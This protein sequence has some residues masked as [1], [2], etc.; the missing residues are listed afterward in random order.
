M[1]KIYRVSNDACD[2][3]PVVGDVVGEDGDFMAACD[4]ADDIMHVEQN[5]SVA[6]FVVP[7][8]YSVGLIG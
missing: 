2:D 8:G 1:Y 5:T 3:P 7:G 6:F 4:K